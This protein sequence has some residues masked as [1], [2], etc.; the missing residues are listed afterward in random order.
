MERYMRLLM[1]CIFH[2]VCTFYSV[3]KRKRSRRSH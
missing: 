2:T 1:K 3:Q